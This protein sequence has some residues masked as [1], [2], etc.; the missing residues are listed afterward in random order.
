MC[1]TTLLNLD[2]LHLILPVRRL[3]LSYFGL[4]RL[5]LSYLGLRRLSLS[6]LGLGRL[7]HLGL[8]C[9]SFALLSLGLNVS[10]PALAAEPLRL[11]CAAG[12]KKPM[13][14]VIAG[15]TKETGIKVEPNYGASGGLYA[16]IVSGQPCD[17]FLSA[18]WKFL[19]KLEE[20][21]LLK[22]KV[23]YLKDEI[24]LIVAPSSKDKVKSFEDLQKRGLTVTVADKRAPVGEY[25]VKGLTSLGLWEKIKPQVKAMP[26]TVNQVAIMVQE[27]QI[28]A[29]LTYSSVANM[30]KL[31]IVARMGN[32]LTGD[33]VFGFGILKGKQEDSAAQL[34]AYALKH[35]QE[36]TTYGWKPLVK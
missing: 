5:S 26:T 20:E 7:R 32:D 9:L 36:F 2:V 29:G 33:I 31:P 3:S 13:D 19:V 11:Y 16:Q 27:D 14:V 10:T 1:K 28:D 8:S 21:K 4:R 12:L 18:D 6:H 22:S 17:V 35:V 25:S 30:Y 23:A 24:V 15:F 34:I